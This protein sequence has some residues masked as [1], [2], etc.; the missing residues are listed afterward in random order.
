MNDHLKRIRRSQSL[1][2]WGNLI[3]KRSQQ[4]VHT[5]FHLLEH[6]SVLSKLRDEAINPSN[7]EMLQQEYISV[8]C[9]P[10][11]IAFKQ[12][13]VQVQLPLEQSHRTFLQG[14]QRPWP[15]L[16][17][18][19]QPAHEVG[20]PLWVARHWDSKSHPLSAQ[21]LA[22][23]H[24]VS[25]IG[26]NSAQ[27]GWQKLVFVEERNPRHQPSL[28]PPG[29]NNSRFKAFGSSTWRIWGP[30]KQ[31]ILLDLKNLRCTG[32]HRCQL[33][34]LWTWL[35]WKASSKKP[36][37]EVGGEDSRKC[38][39]QGW[40]GR[41]GERKERGK[42][43]RG[44]DEEEKKEAERKEMRKRRGR[45]WRGREKGA[46]ARIFTV[47]APAAPYPSWPWF[48]QTLPIPSLRQ[49]PGN[50]C[51]GQGALSGGTPPPSLQLLLPRV[52]D[53]TEDF[54]A[55]LEADWSLSSWI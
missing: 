19:R 5:F 26:W 39:S 36:L 46:A 43:R 25:I 38:S 10:W 18:C 52:P 29:F 54:K 27:P 51:R 20:L 14:N 4:I 49:S 37:M 55:G 50:A 3:K 17:K 8:N 21:H 2:I 47:R 33:P 44:N 9:R 35:V 24:R 7:R 1:H 11:Q 40:E 12:H 32:Q 16:T 6:A 53:W 13:A 41:R 45:K 15:R 22:E 31:S 30:T 34:L 28:C 42:R 48:L 23:H